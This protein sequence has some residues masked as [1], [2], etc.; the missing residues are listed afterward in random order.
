MSSLC[1]FFPAVPKQ[2]GAGNLG[3]GNKRKADAAGYNPGAGKAPAQRAP[4]KTTS[5]VLNAK[6]L[7]SVYHSEKQNV[8][9]DMDANLW[10]ETLLGP[11]NNDDC[12]ERFSFLALFVS[13]FPLPHVPT[14]Y[15]HVIAGDHCLPPGAGPLGQTQIPR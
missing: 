2:H 7:Y 1:A 3:S 13:V 10:N 11:L 8:L 15:P 4:K 5:D 6:D 12:T 14:A 9:A